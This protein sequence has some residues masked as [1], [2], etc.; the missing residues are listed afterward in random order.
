MLQ[1]THLTKKDIYRLENHRYKVSAF[2]SAL[3]KTKGVA[4]IIDNK[5]KISITDKDSDQG[6]RITFL[7]CIFNG[8]K[9]ALVSVYAPNCYGQKFFQSL[10]NI[11]MGLSDFQLFI[12]TDMNA[13]VDH[14]YDKSKTVN[15]NCRSSN[16]LR[17][18]MSDFKAS[19]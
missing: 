5:L 8:I 18:V 13:V 15:Y 6:G 14:I 10:T 19:T 12:G 9:I 11:L 2:S 3:S 17:H 16:A 1:E 7:K 4:I